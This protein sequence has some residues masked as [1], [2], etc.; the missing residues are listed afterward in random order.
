MPGTGSEWLFDHHHSH[1]PFHYVFTIPVSSYLSSS[2]S[3]SCSLHFTP[4]FHLPTP[5][6]ILIYFTVSHYWPFSVVSTAPTESEFCLYLFNVYLVTYFL[7]VVLLTY[8]RSVLYQCSRFYCTNWDSTYEKLIIKIGWELN[9]L[10]YI[11]WMSKIWCVIFVAF[12]IY[13]F[14]QPAFIQFGWKNIKI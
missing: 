2:F 10:W 12:T 8:K 5:L 6:P 9:K 13:F 4:L 1:T 14:S 3:G 11:S 7:S